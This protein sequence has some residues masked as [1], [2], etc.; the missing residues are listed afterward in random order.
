MRVG[1]SW[2]VSSIRDNSSGYV[3]STPRGCP[4][5]LF[6]HHTTVVTW[7]ASGIRPIQCRFAVACV[8]F[9][10]LP[11][12]GVAVGRRAGPNAVSIILFECSMKKAWNKLQGDVEHFENLEYG[13]MPSYM[14]GGLAKRHFP[15]C[16][17]FDHSGLF[18]GFISKSF[19]CS[20]A[21]WL[22]SR[23]LSILSH[24]STLINWI[25]LKLRG[26]ILPLPHRCPLQPTPLT[27]SPRARHSHP[28]PRHISSSGH[29]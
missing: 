18:L 6:L 9:T 2:Q 8:L 28:P 29:V 15:I 5:R 25:I 21:C 24:F 10:L 4:P 17:S 20:F 23:I 1:H 22:S 19:S 27:I 14:A 7:H 12:Q 3:G 16:Q 13:C 11:T 26:P